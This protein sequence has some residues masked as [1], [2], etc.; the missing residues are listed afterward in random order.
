MVPIQRHSNTCVHAHI[1]THKHTLIHSSY[2]S[3]SPCP[4]SRLYTGFSC[5]SP[6]EQSLHCEHC[7]SSSWPVPSLYLYAVDL[8][9]DSRTLYSLTTTKKSQDDVSLVPHLSSIATNL[10]PTFPVP[11]A[12]HLAPPT[13]SPH[14]SSLELLGRCHENGSFFLSGDNRPQFCSII[15]AQT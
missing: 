6:T 9:L 12:D 13:A 7:W 5:C 14:P 8:L 2:P 15:T 3:N 11:L 10:F 4:R 1:H